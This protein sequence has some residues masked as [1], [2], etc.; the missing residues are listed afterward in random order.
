MNRRQSTVTISAAIV[1]AGL[2]SPLAA[3]G[4]VDL[5]PGKYA[6]TITYEVQDLRQNQSRSG[7]RCITPLDLENPES[8]FNDRVVAGA[9]DEES[10]STRN[11]R[12]V[13]GKISYDAECSNRVVHVEGSL[14]HTEFSVVRT[15]K[16]KASHGVSLKFTLRG[17]RTGDCATMGERR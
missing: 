11:L 12:N 5:K 1:L 10:C 15:V 7:A 3:A 13:G 16:P 6:L 4:N 14:N 2:F 8:I 9:K 17:R